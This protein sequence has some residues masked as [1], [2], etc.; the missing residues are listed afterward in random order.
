MSI[1]TF[2]LVNDRVRNTL[3]WNSNCEKLLIVKMTKRRS[4]NDWE[5]LFLGHYSY[6]DEEPEYIDEI[7]E[8]RAPA[9]LSSTTTTT[10]TTTTPRPRTRRPSGPRV[11]SNIRARNRNKFK[12]KNRNRNRV[13]QSQRLNTKFTD[14]RLGRC[15]SNILASLFDYQF[16]LQAFSQ[17]CN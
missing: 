8:F 5:W 2:G 14:I 4:T 7:D 10:T 15:R 11:K 9:F 17:I 1:H 13:K 12:K 6:D 16:F 3:N